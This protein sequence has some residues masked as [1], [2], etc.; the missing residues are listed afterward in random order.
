MVWNINK[1]LIRAL[2]WTLSIVPVQGYITAGHA[3]G[4]DAPARI[5]KKRV[6]QYILPKKVV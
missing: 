2:I 5:Q 3:S 1:E 6:L 4:L